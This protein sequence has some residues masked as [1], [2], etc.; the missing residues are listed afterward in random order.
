MESIMT[1]V[2]DV[3]DDDDLSVE[4]SFRCFCVVRLIKIYFHFVTVFLY[5]FYYYYYHRRRRR[6]IRFDLFLSQY[7]IFINFS[8]PPHNTNQ[9]NSANSS[10]ASSV[11]GI[12]ETTATELTDWVMCFGASAVVRMDGHLLRSTPSR[13]EHWNWTEPKH[14]HRLRHSFTPL[15]VDGSGGIRLSWMSIIVLVV[16]IQ[17]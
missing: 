2:W 16:R 9:F 3:E 17:L 4:C 14:E 6:S 10:P 11:Y 1:M 7:L 13:D 15:H 8:F 12:L 5:F